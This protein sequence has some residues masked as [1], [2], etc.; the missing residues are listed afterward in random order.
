ML[1]FFII[2]IIAIMWFLME[3]L[4]YT[5]GALKGQEPPPLTQNEVMSQEVAYVEKIDNFSLQ[6]FNQKNQLSHT[7][8]AKSYLNFKNMP[9]LLLAP[10]VTTFNELDEPDYMLSSD[11]ANY[12]K[13]GDI[14]FSGDVD[15]QSGNGVTHKMQTQELLIN[16]E[17][18]DLISH[19]P[20]TYLGEQTRMLSQGMHMKSKSDQLKLTGKTRI[21]QDQGATFLTKDLYV[22]QSQGQKHY[23]SD[24]DTTYL[25]LENKIYAQGLDMDMLNKIVQLLGS[26]QILQ[27]TGSKI[28]TKDLIVDQSKDGEIYRTQEK[29]H[30]HSDIANIQ[31]TGMHYDAKNQK[32]KLTGGVK[33]RYE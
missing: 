10:K 5:F 20:V 11:R 4:S 6:E 27:N 22:D 28:D 16:S 24:H 18:D 3:I 13:N 1:G 19:Q 2:V 12:L 26:V 21:I 17:T 9:A 31:A 15:V 33:G 7:V 25:A 14:K 30:Y 29:I 32:I 8:K 23:Y